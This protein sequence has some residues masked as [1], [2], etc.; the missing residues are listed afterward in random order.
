VPV[1][2]KRKKS[3]KSRST[4]RAGRLR[5]HPDPVDHPRY[6]LEK[7]LSGLDAYR[8]DLQARRASLAA[9]AAGPVVADLAGRAGSRSD[10]ELEDELCARLGE[11]LAERKGQP[12][13]DYVSPNVLAEA[14]VIAA[15]AAVR[16]SLADVSTGSGGGRDSWRVLSSV[17]RIVHH[18]LVGKAAAEVEHLR[19]LPGGHLL[20]PLPDGPA[21]AGQALWTRDAY[22]SRF[23]IAAL[24]PTSGGGPDRWYLWDIDACGL[25]AFTV[26]SGYHPTP[27]RALADW[28]SGV[29]HPAAAGTAFT[30]VDDPRLLA[31]LLPAEEGFL[32]IGGESADQFAEYHRSRRLAEAVLEAVGPGD[33][34]PRTDLDAATATTRFAAWLKEHRAG[35]PQPD[36][37]DEL[38]SELADSWLV[39]GPA[40]LYHTCSPHRVA[41]TVSHVR[42]YYQHDFAA[43][44][45]ALLP[46]WIY[47][48]AEHNGTPSELADRCLPYTRGERHR[49]L[50]T[51]DRGPDCFAR[52]TE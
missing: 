48:L 43:R 32:R 19:G 50:G 1:S 6:E 28:Q 41:L 25:R 26:H 38:V 22:G 13:D 30:P 9:A 35:Q 45:T 18:P 5:V 10:P 52:V 49:G 34:A 24:F 15:A 51:D 20:P 7:A 11:W 40:A 4:T 44:L 29:G 36:D 39:D 31:D 37:L 12:V 2:R 21:V 33:A 17:S 16:A 23:A 27:E 42:D 14:V 8:R 46:D 3:R 47:W